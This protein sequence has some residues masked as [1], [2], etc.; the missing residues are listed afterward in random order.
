MLDR[1]NEEAIDWGR[2]AIRLAEQHGDVLTVVRAQNA[3]GSAQI[4]SGNLEEGAST[5]EAG[6][7]AAKQQGFDTIAVNLLSNLGSAGGE[8]YE[9][10]IAEHALLIAVEDARGADLD[11]PLSYALAWLALVRLFQGRWSESTQLSTEALA[12]AHGLAIS[13]I[14]ALIA[15]GRVRARRGDPGVWEA[16]DAALVLAEPTGTLQRIAPVSAAR[17]EARWLD[18]DV[19]GTIEEA[20]RAYD[21]AVRHQHGWHAGELA[22]W[23]RMAGVEVTLPFGAADPWRLTLDG[24]FTAAAAEWERRDCPYEAARAQFDSEDIEQL[25]LALRTFESLGARPMALR[26]TKHLRELGATVVP[27]G[28]RRATRANPAGLTNREFEVLSLMRDGST[29]AEIGRALFVSARTVEHHV[30]SILVKLDASS[31]RDAITSAI[32]RG[33]LTM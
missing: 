18:G 32:D 10:A 29:N 12:T 30:S 15:L 13:R 21:L 28:P 24:I 4:V 22:Y 26:T 2:R 3:I 20:T 6:I 31:R 1:H 25:R 8:V 9:L 11:G 33:I 5:L 17:A 7:A 23:L 14:M 27:R 19:S 16:L